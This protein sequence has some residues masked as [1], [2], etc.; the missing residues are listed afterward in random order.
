MAD[1]STPQKGALPDKPSPRNLEDT[2]S[3]DQATYRPRRSSAIE[4]L[5]QIAVKYD[6]QIKAL[7]DLPEI[8]NLTLPEEAFTTVRGQ[9]L[10]IDRSTNPLAGFDDDDNDDAAADPFTVEAA[11]AFL[12]QAEILKL[13]A[14]LRR[15]AG[16]EK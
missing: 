11:S 14:D 7:N 9:E 3:K 15:E 16:G 8:R 1:K 10:I 4:E 6:A 2:A 13:Q 5:N 12:R